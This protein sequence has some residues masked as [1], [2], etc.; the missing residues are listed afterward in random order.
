MIARNSTFIYKGQPVDVKRVGR[1]LG[2]RYV[3]EGSV[4]KAGNRVR[5]TGQLIDTVTAAHL[6]AERFD[7]QLSDVFDLQD[8]V[9]SRVV[10]ALVSKIERAELEHTK[11]KPT[12]SL[13]A[14]DCFIRGKANFYRSS[15]RS[16]HDALSLFER[17]FELDSEFASAYAMAA[18]CYV[19]RNNN[20]WL[21]DPEKETARMVW[22]AK[23]AARLGRDDP[24]A[25]SVSGIVH[26]QVLNDLTTGATLLDRAVV[27]APNL[28]I[29]WNFSGWIRIYLGQA[30]V[31][32]E[33]L[34]RSI[35]LDPLNP[36][37]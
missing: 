27:L 28:A 29:A 18:W 24:L 10:A 1:E 6:W 37:L 35:R 2:V 32:I 13:S 8:E 16:I 33:H 15:R 14:Y 4:R 26:A 30:E 7:G 11:R 25:L 5:V 17:A 36:F 31:A 19:V 34:E 22:L 23:R 9:T 12:E 3:L 20:R 21:I